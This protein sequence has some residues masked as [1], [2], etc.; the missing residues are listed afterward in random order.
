MSKPWRVAVI[1]AGP[2]GLAVLKN[3][4]ELNRPDDQIFDVELLDARDT[5]GG[6]WAY[7]DNADIPT[8]LNNTLGN[9]SK[10]R[11]CYSDFP[12]DEALGYEVPVYLTQ[13]EMITYLEKYV[14]KFDL[15]RYIRF[16]TLVIN[17]D[18]LSADN[19][20]VLS[21]KDLKTGTAED[22]K[23][24]KVV[25]ATG[26]YTL[27]IIPQMPGI[28][29]FRGT[30]MHSKSYKHAQDFEGK[31][32]LILGFG[33]TAADAAAEL[34]GHASQIYL[35]HRRGNTFLSRLINKRP[36]E[37]FSTRR[38]T[39]M[40]SAIKW[41]SPSA[42]GKIFLNV[43]ARFS[44]S[45]AKGRIKPEWNFSP[46]TSIIFLR[47]L[48][49]ETIIDNLESGAVK[50]VPGMRQVI[51][52]T[53]VELNDGSNVDVDAIIFCT[54]YDRGSVFANF[55]QYSG[56]PPLAN[57]YYNIFPPDYAD[58]LAFVNYWF[59]GTGICEVADLA[60]MAIAQIFAGN[61]NLPSKEQMNHE[62]TKHHATVRAMAAR[63]VVHP[64][65]AAMEKIVDEGSFRYFLHDLAKT[66]VNEKLGYGW[67]G[68]HFWWKEPQL[69]NMLM[70][71]IEI[72]HLYR[73]F[74]PPLETRRK[75]WPDARAAIEIAN[76]QLKRFAEKSDE[77]Q[78]RLVLRQ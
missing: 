57:L 51:S 7:S 40:S 67:E 64:T 58:S 26:Q 23:Y 60:A 49:S 63:E 36:L 12:A 1:G 28:E 4:L 55:I 56:N 72:P 68:W 47:P 21:V 13:P 31:R 75:R 46:T 34:V 77:E 66:R 17:G 74:E 8:T 22:R 37:F 53:G 65:G 2:Q 61:S 69:C 45:S 44:E 24:D 70:T 76:E 18:R 59:I 41:A 73:L 10:W 48:I 54:G 25:V 43:V 15:R 39:T 6:L 5:I 38:S 50:S 27:P 62:I 3:L 35:S 20:W 33:I 9:I 14:D 42:F 19:K 32:V 71:G 30:V 16:N 11:N 52:D 29:K 78:R